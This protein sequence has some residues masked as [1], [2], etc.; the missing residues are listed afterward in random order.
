MSENIDNDAVVEDVVVEEAAVV[1]ET[2]E[3]V[4][5]VAVVE[6]APVAETPKV[7]DKKPVTKAQVKDFVNNKDAVVVY[8]SRKVTLNNLK[9][10][11]SEGFNVIP[12]S[13]ARYWLSLSSVRPAT[14]A[15]VAKEFGK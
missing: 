2:P 1:E 9:K 13:E 12:I 8:A 15:E 4:E 14:P 10:S 11:L 5:E 6:E 7:E 3:V